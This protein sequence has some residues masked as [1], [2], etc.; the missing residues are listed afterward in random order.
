[1]AKT[2]NFSKK[3]LQ[4]RIAVNHSNIEN[5][6]KLLESAENEEKVERY[7]KLITKERRRL[8]DNK[9]RLRLFQEQPI[10][11]SILSESAVEYTLS[12]KSMPFK[13][14]KITSST[15]SA[16]FIRNFYHEDLIIYESV[17]ILLLDRGNNTV[18]YA[19]I[20]QGGVSS[21]IVDVKIILKYAVNS[22]ASGVILAHNHPTGALYPSEPDLRITK[23]VKEALKLVDSQLLDHVILTEDSYY[24]F[25]DNGQ[26]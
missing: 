2:T 11:N 1:M 21:S 19:K 23:K 17:F 20:S 16:K 14:E 5:F 4:D 7:S 12:A 24:S 3:Q 22:L 25:A 6:G 9:K 8:R 26:I 10:P 15:Q 13:K 18:G